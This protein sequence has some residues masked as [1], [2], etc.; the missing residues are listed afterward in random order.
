MV[1]K[2]QNKKTLKKREEKWIWKDK[3]T[4]T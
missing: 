4:T 2:S 1:D 3:I